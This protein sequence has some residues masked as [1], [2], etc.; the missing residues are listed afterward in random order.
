MKIAWRGWREFVRDVVIVVLGVLIALAADQVMAG[1]EWKQRAHDNR[2]AIDLELA[3]NAGVY[4]ERSL[5]Q[6]CADARLAELDQLLRAA[7]RTRALPAIGRIGRPPYRPTVRAA[8][9]E[10]VGSQVLAYFDRDRRAKLALH[11]AQ[12]IDYDAQIKAEAAL[13]ATLHLVEDAPGPISDPLL[14][15]AATAV[16]RLRFL[17][18]ING[19]NS[20]Q[21]FES[22]QALAIRPSYYIVFDREGTRQELLD[23]KPKRPI[24]KPL[25][26][27][28]PAAPQS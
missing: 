9:D 11:Y 27:A 28:A 12:S 26:G 17:S 13:W 24:C 14:A 3:R 18:T 22:S 7:R 20:Q 6:Q 19:L 16:A 5:L 10:A 21:L 15:E 25:A 23:S 4:E 1:I 8:W 2:R